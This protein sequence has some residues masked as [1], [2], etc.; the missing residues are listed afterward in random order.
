ME[1]ELFRKAASGF[2][3]V[4]CEMTGKKVREI[5]VRCTGH[6]NTTEIVWK[7]CHTP[8]KQINIKMGTIADVITICSFM[9]KK[10][11]YRVDN[12]SLRECN[13]ILSAYTLYRHLR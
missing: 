13:T 8:L 6:R 10:C 5:I 2:G 11:Q 4:L 12:T 3:G 7:L 9:L 1:R